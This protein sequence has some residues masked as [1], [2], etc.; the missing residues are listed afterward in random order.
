M[1]TN[2]HVCPLE[3]NLLNKPC[4]HFVHLNGDT[5]FI[6][7]QT[8]RNEKIREEKRKQGRDALQY[9]IV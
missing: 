8:F 5:D 6:V 9:K 2:S 3:K 4:I 1:Q 7:F